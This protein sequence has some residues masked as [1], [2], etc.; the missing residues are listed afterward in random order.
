M[1]VAVVRFASSA[2]GLPVCQAQPPSA[3][4]LLIGL[5]SP[6]LRK[7]PADVTE[8]NKPDGCSLPRAL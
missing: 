1:A 6:R 7:K 8:T 4:T 5:P 3:N 2:G